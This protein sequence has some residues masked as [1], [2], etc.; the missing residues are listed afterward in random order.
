M[1]PALKEGL[2]QVKKIRMK[3]MNWTR[4]L[5]K[6][7]SDCQEENGIKVQQVPVIAA[8]KKF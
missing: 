3:K 8:A 6:L 1:K 7:W 4:I 2:T 5:R